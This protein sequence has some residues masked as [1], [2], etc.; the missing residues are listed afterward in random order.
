MS[1][2]KMKKLSWI[3]D[4]REYETKFNTLNLNTGENC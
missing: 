2:E 1:S 4:T 3:L